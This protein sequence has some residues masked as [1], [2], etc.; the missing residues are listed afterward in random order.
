MRG[1]KLGVSKFEG[2]KHHFTPVIS[3]YEFRYNLSM[4]GRSDILWLSS[5]CAIKKIDGTLPGIVD[6]AAIAEYGPIT[7][8]I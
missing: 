2:G 8:G 4:V 6:T 1:V 3:V 7:T 5:S